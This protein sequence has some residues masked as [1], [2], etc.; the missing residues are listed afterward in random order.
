M[1]SIK[2]PNCGLT[3]FASSPAC[4]R[5][6][7]SLEAREYPYW[8]GNSAEPRTPDWSKLQTVPAVPGE[9]DLADFGD[10]GHTTGNILFAVYLGIVMV[11]SIISLGFV[12]SSQ[13][14]Q[15]AKLVTD[16]KNAAYMPTF[17]S[18]YYLWTAGAFLFLLGPVILLL[19]I[20]V[21][22]KVFLKLVMIYL[23]VEFLYSAAQMSLIF[24]FADELRRKNVPQA[25][26]AADQV[27]WIPYFGIMSILLTFI[28]FRYFWSSKRARAVFDA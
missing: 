19:T 18:L 2:C 24:N 21:K 7:Q 17:Q 6:K 12:S 3:N 22:A 8:S 1:S 23:L 13:T 20:F 15:F 5:C 28:W 14:A 10:G 9:M 25:V 16:P 4:K 27:Q 26:L 11:L